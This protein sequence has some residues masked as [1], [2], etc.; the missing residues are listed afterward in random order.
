MTTQAWTANFSVQSVSWSA[1]GAAWFVLQALFVA[2]VSVALGALL[3][4]L[5]AAVAAIPVTFWL[6]VGIVGVFAYATYP[7][8]KGAHN[9]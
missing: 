9:G 6:A 7:K 4:A 5:L 3:L 8:G 1:A 2:L